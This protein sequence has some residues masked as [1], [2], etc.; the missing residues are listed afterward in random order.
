MIGILVLGTLTIGVLGGDHHH[1]HDNHCEPLEDYGPL[2]QRTTSRTCCTE[3][4]QDTCVWKEDTQCMEV[5]DLRCEVKLYTE[6]KM[7]MDDV[8]LNECHPES[9]STT[10]KSCTKTIQPKVH[11]KE[12]FECKNVTKQH[13]T[14]V[15]EVVD[16]QKVWT[17]NNDC[18]DVTWEDCS[19]VKKNVTFMVPTMNCTDDIHHYMDYKTKPRK[20]PA[21]STEC[22]VKKEQVCVPVTE[23]KCGTIKYKVCKEA[24][25]DGDCKPYDIIIP[26]K[27]K[28]H[29]KW[30]LLDDDVKDFTKEVT[31]T[32]GGGPPEDPADDEVQEKADSPLQKFPFGLNLR[33]GLGVQGKP[34]RLA[35]NLKQSRVG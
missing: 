9:T 20:E 29:L 5:T 18:K 33:K 30:C 24:K 14:T 11:T 8:E 3:R 7:K 22:E 31:E 32:V 1:H 4:L 26:Y 28:L 21:R 16:G 12:V 34:R 15:W 25:V 19:P 2:E 27:K 6:C 13:C 10:L 17:G 35:A 23:R